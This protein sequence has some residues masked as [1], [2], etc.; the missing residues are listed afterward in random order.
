MSG[1]GRK[2]VIFVACL[3][4]AALSGCARPGPQGGDVGPKAAKARKEAEALAVAAVNGGATAQA[5]AVPESARRDISWLGGRVSID[6]KTGHVSVGKGTAAKAAEKATQAKSAPESA[7]SRLPVRPGSPVVLYE[8]VVSVLPYP[9]E[10]EAEADALEQACAA[11]ERR[12]SELDPPI[13][14]KPSVEEARAEFV[15]PDSR[16][17]RHPDANERAALEHAGVSAELVYVE[18]DVELTADQVRELR[19]RARLGPAVRVL[20]G[21]LAVALAG[22]LFLRTDQWT[23]GALTVWLALAAAALAAGGV[24]AAVLA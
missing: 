3:V 5:K 12:L 23:K 16:A 17:V 21:F 22:F 9:T 10:E 7:K 13:R 1:V 8:K 11:V 19:A 2:C 20:G 4:F 6:R 18:F 14:H 24:A 15:R